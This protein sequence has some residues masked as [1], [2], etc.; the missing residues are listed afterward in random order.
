MELAEK[1]KEKII[2]LKELEKKS[3]KEEYFLSEIEK[4]VECDLLE[5]ISGEWICKECGLWNSKEDRNCCHYS[6]VKFLS[7]YG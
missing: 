3:P 7:I 1:I 5:D 4:F 2:F 6:I